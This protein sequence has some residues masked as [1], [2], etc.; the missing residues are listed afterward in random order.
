M[1]EC[2]EKALQQGDLLR[3]DYR[4][5]QQQLDDLVVLPQKLDEKVLTGFCYD[6]QSSR[7]FRLKQLQLRSF[8]PKCIEGRFEADVKHF[9]WLFSGQVPRLFRLGWLICV[10][11]EH[12][13]AYPRGE[14]DN[15]MRCDP[16]T[17]HL[18]HLQYIKSKRFPFHVWCQDGVHYRRYNN[19]GSAQAYFM[20][21]AAMHSP[22]KVN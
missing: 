21:L 1:R 22:W 20:Q 10:D 4:Y 3:V 15:V 18:I 17:D 7:Q 6:T 9:R 13:G 5:G 16:F 11:E 2:I 12:S 19:I 8:S 14:H